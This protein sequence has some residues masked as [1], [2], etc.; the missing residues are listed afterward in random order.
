M[1][2]ESSNDRVRWVPWENSFARGFAS[3]Q[4]CEQGQAS[5]CPLHASNHE[6]RSTRAF[7]DFVCRTYRHSQR[8]KR[9]EIARAEARGSE[10]RNGKYSGVVFFKGK[11]LGI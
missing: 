9:R 5:A 8:I 1:P 2:R 3:H 6:C 10:H 11:K 4:L 7:P